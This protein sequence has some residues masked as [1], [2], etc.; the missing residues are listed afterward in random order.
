MDHNAHF[1]LEAYEEKEEVTHT[2]T[3]LQH[4]RADI[5]ASLNTTSTCS[6]VTTDGESPV[7]NNNNNNNNNKMT[8]VHKRVKNIINKYPLVWPILQDKF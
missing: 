2:H 6:L 4:T 8:T 3:Q 5:L 1:K 7:H